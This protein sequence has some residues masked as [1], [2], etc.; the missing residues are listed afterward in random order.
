[1][2]SDLAEE[3]QLTYRGLGTLQGFTPNAHPRPNRVGY[4][5]RVLVLESEVVRTCATHDAAQTAMY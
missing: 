5:A 3:S 4:S 2:M 1:M